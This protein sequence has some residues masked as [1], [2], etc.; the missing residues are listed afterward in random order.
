MRAW[1]NQTGATIHARMLGVDGETVQ[2]ILENGKKTAYPL[3]KLSADD[4]K[5]VRR[6]GWPLPRPWP[7][8]P[9][10]L[11][12][13]LADTGIEEK[14]KV[15][16]WFV[17]QSEHFEMTAEEELATPAITHVARALE[18][19]YQ[20]LA[21]SPWG[22]QAKPEKGHFPIQLYSSRESY[23]KNGGPPNSSG[24]YK[25]REKVF[26]VPFESIGLRFT[27]T[28]WKSSDDFST[29]TLVHELTHMLMAD[30][31][32]VLPPWL[33]EG[34]AEYMGL[35]PMRTSMFRPRSIKK[36]L[37]KHNRYMNDRVRGGKA[38]PL[39]PIFRVTLRDWQT[40][41]LPGATPS[42]AT[43]S[44]SPTGSSLAHI[45]GYYHAGLLLT[46]YFIHLDG[47]GDAAR[48]RRFFAA[49]NH[50]QEIL[51]QFWKEVADYQDEWATF[52]KRPDVVEVSPGRFNFPDELEPPQRPSPPFGDFSDEP[53]RFQEYEILL[54]GRTE[55]EV[56]SE[57]I[58]ALQDLDL[59]VPN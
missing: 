52:A 24:V 43:G 58:K 54:D 23:I 10:D 56:L 6:E 46:Y 30:V 18:G 32:D 33:V 3:A 12:V 14:G 44:T 5:F 41:S 22:I 25:V 20:L 21:T 28:G 2:L 34:T 17:Y 38:A 1:K 59:I 40:G 39:G 16:D 29:S 49:A 55:E 37:Q 42:R 11:L 47:R 8:W 13:T 51:D 4:Q 57:A 35:M 31:I 9:E 27:N 36:E 53:Q 50:N 48:L 45:S 26:L 19:V 15:G 7:G